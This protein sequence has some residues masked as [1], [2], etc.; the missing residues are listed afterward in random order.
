MK[1]TFLVRCILKALSYISTYKN[2]INVPIKETCRL[3]HKAKHNCMVH[4]RIISKAELL[5]E[6]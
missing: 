3:Y 1:K 4:T 6:V 2:V 5:R